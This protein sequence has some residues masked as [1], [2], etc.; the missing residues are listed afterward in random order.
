MSDA[1]DRFLTTISDRLGPKV[2]VTDPGDIAPWLTDWR[3][4]FHGASPAMLQPANTGEV[5]AIVALAAEHRVPLVPQGG[6]TGM[7]GGATPP[8]DGSAVLLSLRR[9]NRVRAISAAD[10]QAVVEAGVIL[11]D[12]H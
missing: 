12:L 5:A 6:N 11:S 8:E 3:G 10:R 2:L 7:C 9:M 1:Q 4:R